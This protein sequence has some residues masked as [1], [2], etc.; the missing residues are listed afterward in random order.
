MKKL[1]LLIL[2]TFGCF[3]GTTAFASYTSKQNVYISSD[4]ASKN[5]SL[6]TPHVKKYPGRSFPSK[7]TIN[8][9]QRG[10][11]GYEITVS[12]EGESMTGA[13]LMVSILSKDEVPVCYFSTWATIHS[14]S[15]YPDPVTTVAYRH[16]AGH[17]KLPACFDAGFNIVPKKAKYTTAP[18]DIMISK[19]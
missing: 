17:A 11:H 1:I 19:K 7:I 10:K 9:G 13:Y 5:Y 12:D 15:I 6:G 3:I 2:V 4:L 18:N 14:K 8:S 16:D